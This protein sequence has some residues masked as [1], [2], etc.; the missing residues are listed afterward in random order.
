MSQVECPTKIR[1]VLADDHAVVRQAIQRMLQM[2]PDL[3]VVGQ[4][5]DGLQVVEKAAQLQPDVVVMDVSMP[6]LSGIEATRRIK[7]HNPQVHI[8]GLSMH[9]DADMG[10]AMCE[11]GASRYLSKGCDPRELLA[12]IQRYGRPES[13]S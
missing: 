6:Y 3:E 11:A 5:G 7:R 12:A 8:I 13:R 1:I 9:D 10:T 4:A 2:E